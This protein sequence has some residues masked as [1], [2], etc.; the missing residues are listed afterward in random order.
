MSAVAGCIH[1]IHVLALQV[2]E[3]WCA[4]AH[5][6]CNKHLLNELEIRACKR[7][8]RV[9]VGTRIRAYAHRTATHESSFTIHQITIVRNEQVMYREHLS[10]STVSN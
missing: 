9:F 1:F 7:S 5:R 8:A 6:S 3:Q 2:N 4:Y 10:Y